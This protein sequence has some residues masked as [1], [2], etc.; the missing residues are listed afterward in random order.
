[1]IDVLYFHSETEREPYAARTL[2]IEKSGDHAISTSCHSSSLMV[3]VCM[4]L[5]GT[6]L[7]ESA[8]C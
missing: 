4:L 7:T 6:I 3:W 8:K 1:M 5:F 2:Q